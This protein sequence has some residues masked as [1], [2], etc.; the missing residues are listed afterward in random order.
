MSLI[1]STYLFVLTIF[2]CACCP[3]ENHASG[4]TGDPPE[5]VTDF[6]EEPLLIENYVYRVSW[7][8]PLDNG[9]EINNYAVYA[10]TCDGTYTGQRAVT[11][12]GETSIDFGPGTEDAGNQL[13]EGFSYKFAVRARN[14]AGGWDSGNWK[15]NTPSACSELDPLGNPAP[16]IPPINTDES[17][18]PDSVTKLQRNPERT[19]N[20]TIILFWEEPNNNGAPIS[21]YKIEIFQCDGTPLEKEI[22]TWSNTTEFTVSSDSDPEGIG[23]PRGTSY[24]FTIQAKNVNGWSMQP[25]NTLPYCTEK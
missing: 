12:S 10:L 5:T 1:R 17:L 16:N 11:S 19:D 15:V 7:D 22:R 9:S 23:L 6:N 25:E 18:P 24:A 8:A 14:I 13:E 21:D 3:T 2:L 4:L 20:E